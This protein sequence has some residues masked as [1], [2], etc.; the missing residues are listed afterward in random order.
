L[1]LLDAVLELGSQ[2]GVGPVAVEGRAVDAGFAGQG[3]DVAVAAGRDLAAQEPVH[4]RPDA[5]V[6]LGSL[7]RAD[8]LGVSWSDGGV[9]AASISAMTRR[10]RS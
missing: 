10:A 5:V 8:S 9:V 2:V 1:P 3:L 4:R 7:G 6:V